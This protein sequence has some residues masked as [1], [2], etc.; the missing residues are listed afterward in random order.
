[1]SK[2]SN[3]RAI[4]TLIG[5]STDEDSVVRDWATFGLGTLTDFDSPEL[6]DALVAR[7]ND[8]YADARFEAM[9]G[10]A[11]RKDNRV[12]AP[13]LEA[14]TANTVFILALEAAQEIA[15][16]RLLPAL[17]DLKKSW[18]DDDDRFVADLD[19]A[20]AACQSQPVP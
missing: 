8:A 20:I 11:R 16:S 4:Q 3:P 5:L 2:Q 9:V 17:M 13:L 19:S 7:L 1:M 18:A 14:L 6:R 12:L 15:D 10:L